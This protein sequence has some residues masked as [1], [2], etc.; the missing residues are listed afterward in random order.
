V[1]VWLCTINHGKYQPVERESNKGRVL[2]KLK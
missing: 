1:N 2:T